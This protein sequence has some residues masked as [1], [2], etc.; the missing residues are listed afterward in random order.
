MEAQTR[1]IAM[2]VEREKKVGSKYILKVGSIR[3]LEDLCTECIRKHRL[4]DGFRSLALGG[5]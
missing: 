4:K 5:C 2:K 1:V 3:F